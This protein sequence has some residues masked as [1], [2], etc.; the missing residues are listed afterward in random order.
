MRPDIRLA[1]FDLDNTLLDSQKGLSERTRR[2]LMRCEAEGIEIVPCT[3]R[4]LK[5]FPD[6]IKEFPG[7]HYVITLN[8]GKV[9]DLINDRVIDEKK[10]PYG[11]AV[12]LM[13]GI[14]DFH[15]MYDCYVDE[16]GY[17][18]SRFLDHLEDYDV[19]DTLRQMFAV[20]RKP[21]PDLIAFLEEMKRPVDKVNFNFNDYDLRARVKDELSSR[22]DIE[23]S[24]SF[25]NNL[26]INAKGATK[27]QGLLTLA[28]YLGI[29]PAQTIGFGDGL[30]D[31]SMIKAAGTGVAMANAID[32]VK[33]AADLITLTN[34]E[35]GVAVALEEILFDGTD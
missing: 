10:L 3:G 27:G 1:A 8:G 35:D 14:R 32:E 11:T 19:P 34:D 25:I 7:I 29:D 26:E 21:V 20:T 13:R 16:Q 17:A 33:E 2:A 24:S 6:C 12:G 31:L 23:V 9:E 18:E 30:N 5:G 22:D 15:V 4:I 28:A